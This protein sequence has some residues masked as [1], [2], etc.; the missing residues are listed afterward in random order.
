MVHGLFR[1]SG[2]VMI[3]RRH[4]TTHGEV[5]VAGCEELALPRS[6]PEP[7]AVREEYRPQPVSAGK[8]RKVDNLY[9]ESI[10]ALDVDTGKMK[11]HFQPSPH[12][13]HDWDAIQTTV[14]IDGSINGLPRKL[15]A[16]ASRNGYFFVAP[17]TTR[18][19]Y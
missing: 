16:Q 9:T 8:G 14:L 2:I 3:Y 5:I 7:V 18:S 4:H 17:N 1:A 12:D 10:V 11:W 19:G 13:T 6:R 15:V